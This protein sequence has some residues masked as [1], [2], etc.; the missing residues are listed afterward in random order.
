MPE[1][2][3]R[4]RLAGSEPVPAPGADDALSARLAGQAGLPDLVRL[5]ERY[6]A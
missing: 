6:T 5:E 1:T 2:T 4:E 3:L